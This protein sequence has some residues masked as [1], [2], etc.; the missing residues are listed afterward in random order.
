M[1]E[2]IDVKYILIT[3]GVLSGIGKGVIASS[4]GVLLQEH[5][6]EITH[7]KIDP[8]L[9]I[10][11]GTMSPFE[12]GECF[13]L[14]DGGEVDLDLG[15]YERFADIS[16]TKDHNITTGKVYFNVIQ[17]ERKG[18]YLGKTVQVIPHIVD[19]IQEWIL[20]V[21]KKS[22][23]NHKF[24][25]N[26]NI[27][28]K[29]CVIEL[30]GTIGDIESM[31]FVEAMRQF[32]FHVGKENFSLVHVSLI[33][34]IGSDKEHKTK[35]TQH[36]VRTLMSLGLV[37]NFLV[38]RSTTP[39]SLDTKQKISSFCHVPSECVIGVH[40]LSNLYQ[41]PLLLHEQ[42]FD[43]LLLKNF[44]I[45]PSPPKE[46][47]GKFKSLIQK[48]EE[49]K[50][51]VVI[52]LVGKYTNLFDS[53]HS[54]I[55]SLE[56]ACSHA[57]RKL[58]LEWIVAEN[59]EIE[60]STED[61]EEYEKTWQTLKKCDGLLIPG[62]FGERGVEGK[63]LAAKYC[64]ENNV[65]YFGICLGMQIAVIEFSRNVL[66]LDKANSTEFDE[67]TKHDV[68][69]FMPEFSKEEKGGTM[70]LGA[71]TTKIKEKFQNTFVAKLYGS[72]EISERHRHRYE[73][74]PDYVDRLEEKGLQFVGVDKF[75]TKRNE[76]IELK[77]HPYF[78]GVQY[79][80]EFKSR[81]FSPSPPFIGF[82]LASSKQDILE[83]LKKNQQN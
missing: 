23:F 60:K 10:D 12:H 19:A 54:V 66:G 33:P 4:V 78:V 6:I 82:I 49:I 21:A 13:V 18:N 51:E 75:D 80:P 57:G 71:R 3:G 15:N 41:V 20:E 44:S 37:P 45:I 17:K 31:A 28:S 42:N 70:R 7:I 62:G 64:R 56:H 35:P 67:L 53:Y 11:A 58:K 14:E 77:D 55:K 76:I 9:N 81:P 59:L 1:N 68:V 83:Y 30:G 22:V 50:I 63:I 27:K 25:R 79:H 2:E 16:L 38:C 47:L 73:I 61:K 65:P 39:V 5:G 29:A 72:N 48:I 8:Y 43:T 46:F 24:Q 52:G 26:P 74:N 34:E 69:M 32:Q 36:S 40:N